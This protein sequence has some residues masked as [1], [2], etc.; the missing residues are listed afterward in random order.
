MKGGAVNAL[1]FTDD[2]ILR[3]VEL[4]LCSIS[5][6]RPTIKKRIVPNES[7]IEGAQ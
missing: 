1:L 4:R 7:R 5:W 2:D 3:R 6:F